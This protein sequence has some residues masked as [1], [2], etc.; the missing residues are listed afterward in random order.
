[1]QRQSL[2]SPVSKLH[3][4]GG[5]DTIVAKDPRCR[6]AE[7]DDDNSKRKASKPRRL[8]FSPLSSPPLPSTSTLEN[9]IHLIPILTLLCFL[10][11]Y[12]SAHAPSQSDLAHFAQ[13]KRSSK[14]GSRRRWRRRRR[15]E[16]QP[17]RLGCLALVVVIVVFRNSASQIFCYNS[18]VSSMVVELG[19]WRAKRLSLQVCMLERE[20]GPYGFGAHF[21]RWSTLCTLDP[22]KKGRHL[23]LDFGEAPIGGSKHMEKLKSAVPDSL[24]RMVAESTLDDLPLT[25]SSLLDFFHSLPQFHQMVKDLSDPNAALCRKNQE[26]AFKLKHDGNRCFAAGDHA[27]ALSCYSQALRV[28]PIDVD[29]GGK[30]LLATIYVNRASLFHVSISM[31]FDAFAI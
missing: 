28:A 5:D 29:D 31:C 12:L 11:L 10:I 23:F 3:S 19:D 17:T 27:Q 4:H 13:F 30:N 8:S 24:R 15:Q 22:Q 21:D 7:D 2:G 25:S 16:R 9:F 18:I 14:P 6:V 20:K 1:M 26:A